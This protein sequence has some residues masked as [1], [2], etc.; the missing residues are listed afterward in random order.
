LKVDAFWEIG[1]GNEGGTGQQGAGF[2]K[3]NR[4]VKLAEGLEGFALASEGERAAL[5]R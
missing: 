2:F 3:S 4:L 5:V 1:M